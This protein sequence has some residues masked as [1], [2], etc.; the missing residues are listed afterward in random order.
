[1]KTITYKRIETERE[2]FA[3]KQSCE[4]AGHPGDIEVTIRYDAVS[5]SARVYNLDGEELTVKGAR[6]Y[7]SYF[8]KVW[9]GSYFDKV[10]EE[11]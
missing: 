7:G 10:K 3:W 5:Q 4:V 2:S 6:W 9:H 8:E 1:M 11:V